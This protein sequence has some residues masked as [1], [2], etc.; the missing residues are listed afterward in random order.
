MKILIIGASGTLG[1]AVCAALEPR[2]TLLRAGRQGADLQVDLR[3]AD[4]IEAMY[5]AID[6]LDAVVVTAGKVHF[7]P[8][9]QID[10]AQWAIG[11][12]DKLMGQVQL[13]QRGLARLRDGGS[14]T[15]TSGLLNDEPI[16]QGASA[17]MVNGALEGFVRAAA[18]ELPRGLRIN[19][20][21]PTLLTESREAYAAFFPG[22]LTMDA[23]Q[24][25]QG[26]VR[27]VE[28]GDTGRVYRM[29]WSRER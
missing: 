8:L 16:R 27:S 28:G 15:L 10:A 14:F 25:A 3:D 26:Y 9:A 18:L 22:T 13:V 29:G 4:R 1:R 6:P 12:Q 2:H 20:V 19:L 21:S 7:G 17:A 11:L 23:A 5:E 24:V